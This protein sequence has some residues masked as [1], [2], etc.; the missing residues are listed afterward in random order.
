MET[1]NIHI[2]GCGSALPTLRHNA[3]CQI[4]EIHGKLFMVDCG[5]GT[6]IQIRRS[7]LHFSKIQAVFI[8]HLHGDH[9]FGLLGMISTFGMTGRTNPL[10]IYAPSMFEEY[11]NESVNLFCNNLDYEVVFHPI[12]TN[13]NKIV[14]EDRSL[15]IETIPLS[16]RI[17]CCGFLFREKPLAPHIKRD[18]IDFYKIPISQINNIKAG[19]SW[20]TDEGEVIPN[21]KLTFPAEKPRSYAYCSDTRYMPNLHEMI[22][23]VTVLYHESTYA[24]DSKERAKLY[25]HSTSQEAAKVAKDAKVRKLLLGHYSS[26]YPTEEILLD[27]AK[28]IFPNSYLTKE[29]MIIKVSNDD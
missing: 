24:N 2:L 5:E 12:Q 15:T 27:E 19:A 13:K 21:E 9:C 8:S 28:S 26:R 20:T 3:S 4:V 17:Q 1:F 29:G 18:L 23:G 6:Q 10:H 25:Y 14:Y 22:S 16:H 7:K 11:F